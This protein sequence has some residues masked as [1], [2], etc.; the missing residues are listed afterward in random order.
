MIGAWQLTIVICMGYMIGAWQ[1]TIVITCGV[2]LWC[3]LA[4][5][6]HLAGILVLPFLTKGCEEQLG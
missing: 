2:P 6:C 3:V 4:P 5:I 1:L